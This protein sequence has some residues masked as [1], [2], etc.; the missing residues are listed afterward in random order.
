M[1]RIN[2]SEES[3]KRN[4]TSKP[5]CLDQSYNLKQRHQGPLLG[6]NLLT[7]KIDE[8]E[9]AIQMSHTAVFA[10]TPIMK[11]DGKIKMG[12]KRCITNHL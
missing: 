8:R 5:N 10:I 6:W 2:L 9:L 12:E 7:C 3:V 11:F 1:K 4:K